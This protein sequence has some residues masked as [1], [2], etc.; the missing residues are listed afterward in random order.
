MKKKVQA[1]IPKRAPTV[2]SLR[3]HR[4]IIAKY[5]ADRS[6]AADAMHQ[7]RRDFDALS[8]Q[9]LTVSQGRDG[10]RSEAETLRAAHEKYCKEIKRKDKALRR[11]RRQVRGLRGVVWM[12]IGRWV[13]GV[14]RRA[15]RWLG[16]K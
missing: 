4:D 16:G 3:A 2:I 5:E 10:W 15:Y 9:Y 14:E 8:A 12:R 1:L 7:M 6:G 13:R 11:R